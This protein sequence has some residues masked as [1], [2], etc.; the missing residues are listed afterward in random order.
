MKVIFEA[1][2]I[3]VVEDV[4][5]GIDAAA[6]HLAIEAVSGAAGGSQHVGNVSG[7]AA[8]TFQMRV[9]V[10]SQ[11]LHGERLAAPGELRAAGVDCY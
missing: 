11:N 1:L 3:A 5:A 7:H 8:Q 10:S 4:D 6:K 9:G 2:F